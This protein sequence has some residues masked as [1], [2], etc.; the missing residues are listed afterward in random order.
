MI[1]TR[2]PRIEKSE[3]TNEGVLTALD[4]AAGLPFRPEEA[5]LEAR[6]MLIGA[7]QRSGECAERTG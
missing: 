6:A 1:A 3:M 5:L 7:V 2:G 4:Q